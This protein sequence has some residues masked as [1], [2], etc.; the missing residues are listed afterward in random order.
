MLIE[1]HIRNFA[2]ID[3]ADLEFFEGLNILTGETGAGKSIL[4]DS[5]NFILG[6]KQSK[7]II[8]A[9]QNSAFAEAVFSLTNGEKI[10][11]LLSNNGIEA[12]A[13]EV[14]IIS[15]EINQSG[16][17]ISRING[18]TV[19]LSNLKLLSSLLLDIHG[20]HEHQSLLDETFHIEI[21]DSFCFNNFNNIKNNYL[22]L[23]LRIKEIEKN[24]DKLKSDEQLKLRKI[25]LLKFQIEEIKEANLSVG[26]DEELKKRR[27]ILVNSEKIFT[28][29]NTCY[30]N[31]YEGDDKSSAYDEIGI[32]ISGLDI[33]EKYDDDIKNINITLKDIYYKLEDVI[34]SIRKFK[35]SIEYDE[36]ELND[37]D[38]RLDL[39]NKLKRKYGNSIEIIINYYNEITKEL[40]EIEKSDEIIEELTLE[41]KKLSEEIGLLAKEMT[42]I[43]IKTAMKLKNN[44]EYELNDL[45]MSKAVFQIDVKETENLT[46]NGINRVVFKI[47]AN[48]GEPPK[49][50]IKVASGGEMSRIMLAIKNAIADID[51]IPT[52]IFDEIDTGI[53]GRTAQAVAEKMSAISKKH[54]LLCVTH[55]PQIA[56]MADAHFKIEKIVKKDKT[57]TLVKRMDNEEQVEELARMLGGAIVTDL[58]KEHSK[59]MI[60]LAKIYKEKI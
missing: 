46:E 40:N 57:S 4:I 3:S 11:E 5:V 59:E 28:N 33:I 45:G 48:P 32:S 19:T 16:R 50:L 31:L 21:L 39:I 9:G 36:Q 60:K 22:K 8:R 14:L 43:R 20:Q 58:T 26:E 1:L 54:Q 51:K 38:F 56:A 44:I 27:D 34:N 52:L 15:R 6:D 55:L 17:S 25:D 29:L 37:I 18:R 7:D 12:M 41:N 10:I 49:D 13:D 2:L 30:Q 23:F 35:S 42:K 47:S 24:L 53:S